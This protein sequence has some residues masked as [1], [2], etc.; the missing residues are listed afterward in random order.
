MRRLRLP[1]SS[2]YDLVLVVVV[3]T[4]TLLGIAM[5]YSASGI[6]ALDALDDPRYFLGWQSLW[7]GLGLVG[8]LAATRIDYHRY[9][10]LA[11]PL[12]L[13]AIALLG[14]AIVRGYLSDTRQGDWTHC[15]ERARG[16]S[17]RGEAADLQPAEPARPAGPPDGARRSRGPQ[18]EAEV[19]GRPAFDGLDA[20]QRAAFLVAG[21]HQARPELELA[22]SLPGHDNAPSQG[23][24]GMRRVA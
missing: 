3:L 23:P 12:L 10:A 22:D 7:A 4:L 2:S 18:D 24:A 11:L 15:G 20:A 19:R 9:R 16:A 14:V 1:R 13:V 17:T 6:K 8:M 21:Q 5:V